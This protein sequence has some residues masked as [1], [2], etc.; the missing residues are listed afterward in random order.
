MRTDA[1]FPVIS[2]IQGRFVKGST[3]DNEDEKLRRHFIAFGEQM[4]RIGTTSTTAVSSVWSFSELEP[5]KSGSRHND[6]CSGC[7]KVG[8]FSSSLTIYTE[9]LYSEILCNSS[10]TSSQFAASFTTSCDAWSRIKNML[11][12]YWNSSFTI[13]WSEITIIDQRLVL[14]S[15]VFSKS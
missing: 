6:I 12:N 8:S 2:T 4:P 3:W 9:L 7:W 11:D 1:V 10:R 5:Q 15:S 14:Q 13:N